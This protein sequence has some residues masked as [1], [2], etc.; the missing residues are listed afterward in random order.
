MPKG[1]YWS[2][3][4][5]SRTEGYVTLA[6]GLQKYVDM[7]L[8]LAMSIKVID[9]T[10]PLCLLHDDQVQLPGDAERYFDHI[11]CIPPEPTHP[12]VM[13]RILI[14]RYT[15]YHR[16]MFVDADC[17]L[18][19]ATVHDYWAAFFGAPF[20]ILGRKVVRGRLRGHNVA[21]IL[22]KF[23]AP[24]TVAMNAG[25]FYYEH[26]F[27]SRRFF[28]LVDVLYRE[29]RSEITR[30][31][32]GRKSQYASEP[33]LGLAMGKLGIEPYPI[34]RESGSL[35]VTTWRARRCEFDFN[36]QFS[37]IE[38]PVGYYFGAPLEA[39]AKGWVI[40]Y[41]VFA[42]FVGLKP[43]EAYQRLVGQVE[44]AFRIKSP[45]HAGTV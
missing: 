1:T 39:L 21:Q 32:Q 41:P 29:H 26:G 34:L 24:Y 7:A 9:P 38:K 16:V 22:R 42:H 10:R 18:I 8:K 12:G 2:P 37:M 23:D 6:I 4:M 30:I 36:S 19:R 40:H 15:P 28:E 3:G 33:L 14:H 13:S 43:R 25:V 44:R 35:V 5:L 11:I 20:A 17:I 45:E 27:E 31:H